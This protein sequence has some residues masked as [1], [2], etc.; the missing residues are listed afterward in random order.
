M[1]FGDIGELAAAARARNEE[2]KAA[3]NAALTAPL[4]ERIAELE[5]LLDEAVKRGDALAASLE[6]AEAHAR[7]FQSQLSAFERAGKDATASAPAKRKGK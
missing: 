1:E 3:K 6:E 2:R 7:T 4:R 5:A